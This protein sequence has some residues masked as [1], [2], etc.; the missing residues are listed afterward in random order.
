MAAELVE[1]H[2]PRSGLGRSIGGRLSDLRRAAEVTTKTAGQRDL[3]SAREQE[4][5]DRVF[6]GLSLA[7]IADSLRISIRTVQSH[8]RN[9][10]RKLDIRSRTELRARLT[11]TSLDRP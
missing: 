6:Q 8:V 11:A 1:I 4:V 10:Y 5:A 3:L 2:W 9:T 7:E